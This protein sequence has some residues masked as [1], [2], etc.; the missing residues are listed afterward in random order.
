MI[1]GESQNK[2]IN[3]PVEQTLEGGYTTSNYD[4]ATNFLDKLQQ[5][6]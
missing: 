3:L 5:M 1:Q 6:K 2:V 4:H